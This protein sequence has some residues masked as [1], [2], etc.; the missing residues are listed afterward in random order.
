M[1]NMRKLMLPAMLIFLVTAACSTSNPEAPRSNE[2][3]PPLYLVRDHA[4]EANADLTG[5][6][7]CHGTDFQGTGNPVPSCYS[8]HE[9]GRP[10]TLHAL[11]YTDP[12]DHGPA[13][14]ANQVLCRG[15]HGDPPNTFDGGIVADPDLYGIATGTCSTQACHPSAKAHPTNWQGTNEDKDL[16]YASTHRTVSENTVKNSRAVSLPLIFIDAEL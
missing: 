13:A 6:Q 8:C 11:P 3:H 15:C 9:S 4:T 10:F 14:R 5:C 1:M 7:T 16:T 12:A 2:T